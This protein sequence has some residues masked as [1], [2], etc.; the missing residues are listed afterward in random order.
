MNYGFVVSV[1]LTLVLCSA[2]A[3]LV[4]QW[5][6]CKPGDG[7][8]LGFLLGPIGIWFAAVFMSDYRDR[9]CPHC[10]ELIPR[11]ATACRACGRDTQIVHELD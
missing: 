7:A 11:R 4:G 10:V 9:R 6:G 5:K 1:F 2:V 3:S 8:V